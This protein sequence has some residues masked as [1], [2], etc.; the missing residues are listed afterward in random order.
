M[1]FKIENDIPTPNSQKKERQQYP[2]E[3][4]EVGESFFVPCDSDINSL[5]LNIQ[6][7]RMAIMRVEKKSRLKNAFITKVF[8]DGIRVWRQ[9]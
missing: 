9:K 3:E 2:L 8:H 4:L 5:S 6:R 1:S 7:I